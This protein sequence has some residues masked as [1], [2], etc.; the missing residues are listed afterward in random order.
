MTDADCAAGES[1]LSC[2]CFGSTDE[3][4]GGGGT[5]G[6]CP[7]GETCEM[8]GQGGMACLAESNHCVL[9]CNAMMTCPDGMTCQGSVCH[10]DSGNLPM[11]GDPNYPLPDPMNMNLCPGTDEQ[12][13]T[14]VGDPYFVC[15]PLCDGMGPMA[16]CP[17]GGSGNAQGACLFNPDSSGNAC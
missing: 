16:M 12:P 1:C 15:A 9:F 7:P 4:S 6:G 3:S 17:A 11:M 8:T 10:Y 14:F 5:A 13:V 2:S